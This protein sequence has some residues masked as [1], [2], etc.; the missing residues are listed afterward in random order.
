[1]REMRRHDKRMDE[2]RVL[3]ILEQADYGTMAVF[4]DEEYPYAVP[5][6]FVYYEKAIYIHC[7][8]DGHKLDAIKKHQKV[9]FTIVMNDK[10]IPEE[11]S[12]KFESVV[13]F[14]KA[15][16]VKNEDRVRTLYALGMK[17]AYEHQEIVESGIAKELPLTTMIKIE[18]DHMTG[19][20]AK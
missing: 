4:G 2:A 20:C 8:N 12:T 14:G 13:I 10:I 6:N 18:I 19:K 3:E 16:I 1:M 7:A 9:G 15:N 5:V 17:Y 11:L